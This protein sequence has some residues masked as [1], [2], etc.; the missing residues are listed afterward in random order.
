MT[1]FESNNTRNVISKIMGYYYSKI[2]NNYMP[3]ILNEGVLYNDGNELYIKIVAKQKGI[4]IENTWIKTN[5]SK[6]YSNGIYNLISSYKYKYCDIYG[7]NPILLDDNDVT[8][9]EQN[10]LDVL[11]MEYI[12]S[13]NEIK[14]NKILCKS[15]NNIMIYLPLI[16]SRIID[17]SEYELCAEIEYKSYVNGLNPDHLGSCKY[18]DNG[19][20]DLDYSKSEILSRNKKIYWLRATIKLDNVKLI[21]QPKEDLNIKVVTLDDNDIRDLNP[22][23]Y[24]D[25]MDAGLV[26][27]S[28]DSVAEIKKYYYFYDLKLIP[29]IEHVQLSLVDY[30]DDIIVFWEGEFNS[31]LPYEL[32]KKL[33]KYNLVNRT[34]N[35]I[36]TAM[37]NWQLMGKWEIF[38]DLYPNQRL[39]KIIYDNY[40]KIALDNQLDFYPPTSIDEY[41]TFINKILSILGIKKENLKLTPEKE[42]M[43]DKIMNK[44]YKFK[45]NVDMV[46]NYYGLCYI[47]VKVINHD[48]K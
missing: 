2:N 23:N 28:S 27:F 39:A 3:G 5:L 31:R 4:E 10:D 45:N 19:Y 41:A 21:D 34:N 24:N 30:F 32:K 22:D 9:V 35:I 44:D 33:E 6:D 42:E 13:D 20:F 37:F 40:K 46:N 47:I 12:N 1:R 38:N 18:D 16:R 11:D 17:Y 48:E 25:D 36:S 15:D 26:V 43:L 8:F 14:R 7:I 29:K